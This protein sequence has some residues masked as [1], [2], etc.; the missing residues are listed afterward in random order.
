MDLKIGQTIKGFVIERIRDNKAIGGRLVEMKHLKTGAELCWADNNAENKLFCIAFRTIPENSTGVFHILEHSVLC[1]SEKYPVKEPFVDLIKSSMNTFLNAMTY[2]DKTIY[3]VSSRNE[4]D[5][6][7]L[8]S[9]YLD[10]VFAPAL[11][12]NRS[13]FLQEGWHFETEEDE[14]SFNG[15][16]YNE[17]KGAMNSADDRLG[18]AVTETLFP[19]NC[20]KYNSGGAPEVIPELS[21]EM[22]VDTYKRFYHP[23]NSRIFLDGSIPLER[24]L[25]MIDS[26]LGRY[27]KTD[28][29]TEI[30]RQSSVKGSKSVYFE[31][32]E[33]TENSDIVSF[34][35][36]LCDYDDAVKSVASSVICDYLAS[37]NE[38]PL[39][40]ALL[41]AGLCEDADLYLSE[42][43]MQLYIELVAR[44][45]DRNRT[46]EIIK[47]VSDTINA[48]SPD[49]AD[50]IA[51]INK[52]EFRTKNISEPQG[53]NRATTALSSWLYGGDPMLYLDLNPVFEKV[54]EMAESG[55]LVSLMREIFSDFSD[56]STV[57]AIPSLTIGQEEAEKE[58]ERVVSA[59]SQKSAEEKLAISKENEDLALW[60]ETPDSK[61]AHDTLPSLSLSDVNPVPDELT[62]EELETSGIKTLFHPAATNGIVRVCV[63]FPITSLT[64]EEITLASLLPELMTDL[65][66]DNYSLS[67]L[68]R[69]IKT[70]IGSLTFSLNIFAVKGNSTECKPCI[71]ARFTT[72]S[73]NLQK[74]QELLTEIINHTILDNRE[75]IQEILKQLD[76]Q[77]RQDA[78]GSGHSLGMMTVR[79]HYTSADAVN[80]AI[81]GYTS[82]NTIHRLTKN[83][84]SE[85]EN[86]LSTL[87]KARS[88]MCRNNAVI[89]VTND[90]MPDIA[91]LADNLVVGEDVPDYASYSSAL[92]EKMGIKIPSSVA[93]AEK[94]YHLNQTDFESDGSLQVASKILT[95]SHL[96]NK[97]RVQG[98][99][100]GV[101]F[102]VGQT[103]LCGCYSY[104][105]PD[106]VNSISAYDSMSEFLSA[107]ASDDSESLDNYII[108]T[109]AAA[110]P[111]ASPFVKGSDADYFWFSK[112]TSE[113]RIEYRKQMLAT[114]KEK[115]MSWCPVLDAMAQNG[116]VCIVANESTLSQFGDITILE[117]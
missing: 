23:S 30:N 110:N 12:N 81:N 79:S 54:R 33:L 15:V 10:A 64:K 2:P 44:N 76:E 69:E 39:K 34:S 24:T 41:S 88:L 103:G 50:L 105:D 95:F 84:D 58:N 28:P 87:E 108:S 109:I 38:S 14:V 20:Y 116:A 29:K 43:I 114:T 47:I 37:S 8:M 74:S 18:Q 93:F 101:G 46:A 117:L 92:P 77:C 17:M 19:D 115:L 6:M 111:L 99:A 107:F 56:W 91:Y 113:D 45:T 100:Y 89:S 55:E 83:F 35:K 40:K 26:Y 16:V 80:E 75:K 65:P 86:L 1:G 102:S 90:I 11:L 94:G 7:N 5:F 106:P 36:I 61:E 68:Q 71:S 48:L 25:E 97:V 4:Q 27:E 22:F 82:I 60:Q 9:V 42:E 59:Y 62:T 85:Y 112:L 31:T 3:P 67:V 21:Y 32:D 52:L 63:Y 78:P 104:R 96:W 98:G 66:T 51:S 13:V 53:L 49:R 73:H 57:A 72:L 70:Y